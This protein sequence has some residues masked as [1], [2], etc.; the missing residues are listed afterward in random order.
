MSEPNQ[1]R[2]RLTSL[3]AFRGATI[4]GMILVNNPGSWSHVYAPLLHA[5]WHGWTPTDLIFPFFLFIVGVAM[6]I[7]FGKRLVGDDSKRQLARHVV[8]RSAILFGLGLFMA[9]FPSF[10]DWGTLRIPG[11]LQRIG[12]VYLIAATLYLTVGAWGRW[13]ALAIFLLGYWALITLVPVPGFGAGDLSPEGNLGAY[14]DRLILGRQHLYRGDMW[15]PEGLL[16]TLPAV[17]TA[18]LGIF[19]GEWLLSD[20]KDDAKVKGLLAASLVAVVLGLLWG[21]LFPINKKI[22][23]S[24]YVVFSAGMAGLI[25]GAFYWTIEL[26]RWK[27]WS[28]PFVIYGMNAIA[29][30]VASGL[31]TK[32]LVRVRVP[33]AAGESTS[34]YNWIYTNLFASWAGPLH[35]SCAFALFYVG[36]WLFLMWLLYRRGIF[37]KI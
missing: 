31:L 32:T 12:V 1:A 19:T 22:W 14:L 9:L 13:S 34:L 37:I 27:R 33:A 7:S 10:S 29:V 28:R 25:L 26:W 36:F 20:R 23:T 15:D 16:S 24:S 30:F 18:L 21:L 35:G 17:G 8:R 5:D 4:A 6:P 11:V 2:G 3:D